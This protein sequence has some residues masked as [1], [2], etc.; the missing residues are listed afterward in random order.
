MPLAKTLSESEKAVIKAHWKQNI[1]PTEISRLWV[2]IQYW[3]TLSPIIEEKND[4]KEKNILLEIVNVWRE[5]YNSFGNSS[6]T[7]RKKNKSTFKCTSL[8]SY[9]PASTRRNP[10]PDLCEVRNVAIYDKA[11]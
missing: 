4:A 10:L 11:P 6:K 3:F 5:K 9:G 8:G 2:A 1:T 7:K